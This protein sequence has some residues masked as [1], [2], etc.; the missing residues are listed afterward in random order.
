MEAMQGF[1]DNFHF[2]RPLLLLAL[3]PALLLG[4]LLLF[5][6]HQGS[7]WNRAIDPALLPFLLDRK[8][9]GKH[10]LH[11]FGLLGIWII[12]IIALA[13]PVWEQLPVPVQ[14]R[15]DALVVVMDLS[16]SMHATDV[17]P[18]RITRARRKLVD[19]LQL[20]RQEG[21]SGLI[22]YAGDAH[23]VTPL[24][25]DVETIQNL[26]P[27]L[28]P[29]IMPVPG[30]KPEIGVSMAID[31][32]R[33]AGID[34]GR[35]M[36]MTDGISSTDAS[37]I[38][39]LI[40]ATR[41][42]FSILG[43]GSD[44][45]APIPTSEGGFLRDQNNAIVIPRLGRDRLQ[46]LVAGVSGRYADAGLDDRDIV[47][48]LEQSLLEDMENLVDTEREYDTWYE[49][50][51]W[52]L[53]LI[54]PFAALAFRQGWMMSVVLVFFLVPSPE[55]RALDWDDLWKNRDQRATE[56]FD[57]ENY[58]QAAEQFRDGRWRAAS[59]YRQ[60]NYEAAIAELE[61]LDDA[62]SHYNRGNAL[63]RMFRLE[64]SLAAY[65]AALA[66]APD[67][68]D[69]IRNRAIVEELLE[70]QQEQEQQQEGD[71]GDNEEEQQN[72]D[73]E[74][75]EGEQ[76]EQ[77][78]SNQ[79]EDTQE[80]DQSQEPQDVESDEQTDQDS[81][82][83]QDQE[84]EQQQQEDLSEQE[85]QAEESSQPSSEEEQSMQQW[86]SRI[87]DD[88]AELLRNKFRQQSQQRLFEQL[89]DPDLVEQSSGEQIW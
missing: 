82:N 88:P 35:I 89:R 58:D 76:Q 33:N 74:S 27:A 68:E 18:D 31:L 40:G 49:A 69:A 62:E 67:N 66:L 7:L 32:L 12:A 45:G 59:H 71:E 64:E 5:L 4:F 86:L 81:E 79:S 46:E 80:G 57:S 29:D 1:I 78:Q 75:Q 16:L 52:L 36:L 43:I 37:A 13:G 14:E 17:N 26:V 53:L 15:E 63:A 85:M 84:A 50:G 19:T 39:S 83:Q 42:R 11:I 54:L 56:A 20:R 38:S 28:Q 8:P 10:N 61:Q 6:H 51:P 44:E 41:H 9:A 23:I 77:D 34:Q 70:E 22:V 2:L 24:T 65:D 55:A 21:Q 87:R 30:S 47:Y 72:Q 25:N 73:Q 3:L 48:L 60:G